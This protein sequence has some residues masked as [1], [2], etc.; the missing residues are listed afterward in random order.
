MSADAELRTLRAAAPIWAALSP[1]ARIGLLHETLARTH[2]AAPE[3]VALSAA[4]KGLGP[5]SR[6]LG[7]EWISGPWAVMYAI[8][9]YVRDRKSVV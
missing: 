5:A 6:L 4:A 7:E 1:H 2:A 9:R 3:W 8:Y